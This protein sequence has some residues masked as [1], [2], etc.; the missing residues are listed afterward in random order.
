MIHLFIN[1]VAANAGG[2]LTYLRNFV[3]RLAERSDVRATVLISSNGAADLFSRLNLAKI[4]FLQFPASGA[5]SRF[6][7]E[8]VNLPALISRTG[9][10][11]LLSTGNFA[12]RNSP[13]PQILLSRNALYTCSY[14]YRDLL[15]RGH[16]LAW[17]QEKAKRTLALRS[18]AWADCTVAP[19]QSFA[20]Q[21]QSCTGKKVL[22]IYHGF[23]PQKFF[24]DDQQPG[25]L[26]GIRSQSNTLR[27][28]FVSHYNYYR[29]FETILRALPLIKQQLAPR[30]V[31]LFL[32]CNLG[33]K[34]ILG[35]YR[36]KSASKLVSALRL[37]D[38][39]VQ[40]GSV[41]YPNLHHLYSACD[42]YV[43][44]AY[45]E[46]FAHPLVEAMACGLPVVASDLSVHREICGSAAAY[47]P[48]LSPEGLAKVVVE[49][50]SSEALQTRLRASGIE[51][52]QHFS[53][54]SHV[55]EIVDLAN[56]LRAGNSERMVSA[57]ASAAD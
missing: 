57:G 42:L 32:T 51:R 31:K 12:L 37:R 56:Q 45:A 23:E 18:I 11:V 33:S 50:A 40:L 27:L 38:N 55:N 36:P 41:S 26:S 52:A 24:S 15:A 34:R 5:I 44:A 10:D 2:G 35:G 6:F 28:L 4:N 39:V 46:S 3:P 19:T 8:Q 49:V 53:W 29:N 47:F 43:T 22:A 17:L 54:T 48:R 21:L 20:N 16:Y 9:A 30:H 25:W 14:F 1:A 7:Q 13:V